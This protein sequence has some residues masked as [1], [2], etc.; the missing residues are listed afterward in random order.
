MSA[1]FLVFFA[2]FW[3]AIV[4]LFDGVM[5]H[6]FWK[7]F[8][9]SRYPF[10]MGEITYSDVT[11]T[12][13]TG[14]HGQS[15]TYGVDIGYRYVVDGRSFN[16]TR[17]RYGSTF[18]DYSWATSTV[19]EHPAHS[20]TKVYFNPNNPADAVLSPDLEGTDLMLLLFLL[21]FNMVMA[22]LWTGAGALLKQR[23]FHSVAGGVKIIVD[24]PRTN[25]RLPEYSALLW[26]MVAT[27]VL[28]F[29]SMFI[30]GFSTSF[31][32]SM[33][34]ACLA[35]FLI[36][37]AGVGAYL[38]QWRKIHSGDDDLVLDETSTTIALPE[39]HGR[40]QRVT[41]ARGEIEKLTIETI[42]HRSSKGGVSYTY[43]PTLW[44]RR[45]E[46]IVTEQLADWMD[47]KRAE[48]FVEWLGQRL[49]LPGA[50]ADVA[51]VSA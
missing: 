13:T 39:T 35:L 12:V 7:Q 30:V 22:G 4:L 33:A 51:K 42:V 1:A 21:P 19:R 10:T 15:T 9:S 6:G 37:A 34:V 31:H 17:Y 23:V 27:G 49:N 48:A 45:G 50:V 25:I 20:Q 38:W 44:V 43:A 16:G 28:S 18:S 32:P 41:V 5:A 29:I 47:K 2:C 36:I 3:S 8:E 40:K 26:G 46:R 24:G 11:K 14:R